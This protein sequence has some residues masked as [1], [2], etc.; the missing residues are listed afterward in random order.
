MNAPPLPSGPMRVA[1]PI[2]TPDEARMLEQ[3]ML[4]TELRSRVGLLGRR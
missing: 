3:A 2:N 1:G 4:L